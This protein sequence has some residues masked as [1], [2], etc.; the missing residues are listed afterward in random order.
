MALGWRRGYLRYKSYF[1]NV[2]TVYKRRKDLR[3]FLEIILSLVTISFFAVFALK[4]TLLT[5]AELTK[6]IKTKEET[7]AKMDE[8]IQN[9]ERGQQIY[10]QEQTRISFLKD[11]IPSTPV[12]DSFVRQIEGATT[13]HPISILGMSIGEVTLIGEEKAQR[14]SEGL[15]ALPGGARGVAFSISA[16]SSYLDLAAF[17]STLQNL[18]RPVKIDAATINSSETDIGK[19]IVLVIT[20]RTPYLRESTQ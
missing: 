1:L 4:P 9:L 13:K 18:R 11:A 12:P 3:M 10:T 14:K 16:T 8:K 2:I 7:V 19:F 15:E 5:I 17:L 6:E 20:G